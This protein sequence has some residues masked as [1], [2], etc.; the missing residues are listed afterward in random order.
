MFVY[1]RMTQVVRSLL[2]LIKKN[3]PRKQLVLVSSVSA[4]T[5]VNN[6][7]AFVV[8]ILAARTLEAE[9]YGVFSLAFSMAT[10]MGAI[11]DLGFNLTMIRLFNKYK[12]EPERQTILLGSILAFKLSLFG[13]ILIFSLPI[14][15]QLSNYL[16]APG[17][18]WL[19]AAALFTGG[20][21]FFWTYLQSYFQ[22]YRMFGKLTAYILVYA[23]LRLGC[24]AVILFIFSAKDEL[25]WLLATYTG[26]LAIL[27]IV[28][29]LPKGYKPL[30]VAT[31]QLRES[32]AILKE[33][34]SYTKWVA[35]SV[36]T[37]IAMP[38]VVRFIL[39]K[40]ASL[41]EVGIFSAG[42]TFTMAFSNL[43]TAVR[44]VLFPQVTALESYEQMRGY[45]KKLWKIAPYYFVLATFGIVI[46][47]ILQWFA[48]GEAYEAALPVFVVTAS[49]FAVVLFLGLGTMLVHTMMKPQIDAVTNLGRLTVMSLLAFIFIPELQ[50]LGAALAYVIPLVVGEIGM[51]WYTRKQVRN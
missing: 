38:Y 25:S 35:L 19:F 11:G 36:I 21:L 16:N 50:S 33:G 1:R 32:L 39:A 5:V 31:K 27:L 2:W 48:L 3:L 26:P 13:L 24:I 7:V 14:G 8:N 29:L 40:R 43:N 28:A 46:L 30:I 9:G 37:Y 18:T 23:G 42:M 15:N 22:S 41:E 47:A 20:L 49:A 4:A 17:E 10:V 6:L 12:D 45:L 34:I 51:F 44:A